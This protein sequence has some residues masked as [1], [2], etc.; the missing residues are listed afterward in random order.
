MFSG[1]SDWNWVCSDQPN[2]VIRLPVNCHLQN[3]SNSTVKNTGFSILQKFFETNYVVYFLRHNS[4]E[5]VKTNHEIDDCINKIN[6][7]NF[8]L[9]E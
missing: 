1:W 3:A 9:K 5:T 4:S 6:K 8:R 7:G 2:R